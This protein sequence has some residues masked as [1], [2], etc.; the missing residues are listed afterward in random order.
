MHRRLVD[1]RT[2]EERG[3][4]LFQCDTQL[5]KPVRP[6]T[7]QMAFEYGFYKSSAGLFCHLGRVDS[8]F[9]Y[10]PSNFMPPE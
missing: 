3:A 10:S 6:L 2:G 1:H 8:T 4:V 9:R 7:A 5:L